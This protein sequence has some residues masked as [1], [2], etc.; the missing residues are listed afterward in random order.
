MNIGV[1]VSFGTMVLDLFSVCKSVSV[2][3]HV[4]KL[5]NKNHMMQKK[6]LIQ[7]RTHLR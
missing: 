4:N 6:L 7:F 1:H 5:K 2:I 3:Q